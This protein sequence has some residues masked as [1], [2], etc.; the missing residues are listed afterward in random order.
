MFYVTWIAVG[1][2]FAKHGL[3][4]ADQSAEHD[5]ML[6][7][8]SVP[9]TRDMSGRGVLPGRG[10]LRRISPLPLYHQEILASRRSGVDFGGNLH[11]WHLIA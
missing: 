9:A 4:A 1:A 10:V 11:M 8:L 7:S 6:R 2:R 3:S 5:N